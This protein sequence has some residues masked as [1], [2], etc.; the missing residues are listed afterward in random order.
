MCG[1]VTMVV[2]VLA[3][4]LLPFRAHN[5][6]HLLSILWGKAMGCLAFGVRFKVEGAEKLLRNEPAIFVSNHQ[7]L[8][9]IVCL[10]QFLDFQFRWMAK[11]SLFRLPLLGW[12]MRAAGYIS[13]ERNNTKEAVRSLYGAAE[14]IRNGNSVVIFPEGTRGYEDG[15][16]RPFKHGSFLLAKKARVMLQPVTIWGSNDVIPM[17]RGHR[18]QRI[19][20]GTIRVMIHDPIHPDTYAGMKTEEISALIHTIMEKDVETFRSETTTG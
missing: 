2:T 16:L 14:K 13:V 15:S 6:V 1:L 7:S 5:T 11:D 3:T 20:P 10:Y 19:Y 17:Q 12:G 8:F 9:D 18:I 4:L